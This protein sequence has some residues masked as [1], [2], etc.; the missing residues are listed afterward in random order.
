M[1]IGGNIGS[2]NRKK[3]LIEKFEHFFTECDMENLRQCEETENIE[4]KLKNFDLGLKEVEK[5]AKKFNVFSNNL[6]DEFVG[7]D[8]NYELVK[9]QFRFKRK[10]VD[11][12]VSRIPDKPGFLSNYNKFKLMEADIGRNL[13]LK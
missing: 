9:N 12:L 4:D 11:H 5:K 3:M 2:K 6:D 8:K 13:S 1:T 7:G 10:I